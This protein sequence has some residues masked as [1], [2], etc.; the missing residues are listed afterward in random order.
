MY[1]CFSHRAEGKV[2]HCKIQREGRI[3]I[4]GTSAEFESLVELVNY[5]RK[6]PLYRK[7]RLRY[8]VT[9]ELLQRCSTVCNILSCMKQHAFLYEAS[10]SFLW[11]VVRLKVW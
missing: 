3:Y 2:K 6:T 9:E 4:I 1:F 7:M 10:V 5:Y 8:P 11:E